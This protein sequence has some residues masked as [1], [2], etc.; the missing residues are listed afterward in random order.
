MPKSKAKKE[1]SA[2]TSTHQ[3]DP[4]PEIEN[5][6]VLIETLTHVDNPEDVLMRERSSDGPL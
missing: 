5:K 6:E 3:A 2:K 4:A 1:N